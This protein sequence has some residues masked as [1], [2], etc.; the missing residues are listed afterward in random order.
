MD[1]YILCKFFTK[2]GN[3]EPLFIKSQDPFGV[4]AWLKHKKSKVHMES[5]GRQFT[6]ITSLFYRTECKVPNVRGPIEN[7]KVKMKCAG[8]YDS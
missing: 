2:K 1:H 5:A 3:K 6:P 8:I 7:E 4:K